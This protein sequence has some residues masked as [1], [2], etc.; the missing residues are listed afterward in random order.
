M[1]HFPALAAAL[2]FL[3]AGEPTSDASDL[4]QQQERLFQALKAQRLVSGE[5][6][7]VRMSFVC[8]L[9]VGA[10]TWRVVDAVELTPAPA[11]HAP[12]ISS[13][14]SMSA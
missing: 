7:L 13:C 9:S 8:E 10:K 14:C 3:I 11:S 4:S 6:L 2:V 1:T 5:T 12:T